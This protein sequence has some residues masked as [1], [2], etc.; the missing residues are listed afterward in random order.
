MARLVMAIAVSVGFRP[1]PVTK[2]LVSQMNR[3]RMSCD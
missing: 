1:A 2:T 3:F